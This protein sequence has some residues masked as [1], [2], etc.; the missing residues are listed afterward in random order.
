MMLT[1]QKKARITPMSIS[2][3]QN[4]ESIMHKKGVIIKGIA[5]TQ[6]QWKRTS[7]R[8][9]DIAIRPSQPIMVRRTHFIWGLR[10]FPCFDEDT[11]TEH[12]FIT[13]S[14]EVILG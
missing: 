11:Y 8:C 9:T 7:T 6:V 3:M 14:N 10:A 2:L 13:A 5:I 4:I 12:H 1:I